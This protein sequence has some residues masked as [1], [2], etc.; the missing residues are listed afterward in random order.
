M[1]ECFSN[2]GTDQLDRLLK[3]ISKLGTHNERRGDKVQQNR[4][5]D[6]HRS[7]YGGNARDSS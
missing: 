6:A 1:L 5:G 3:R 4:Q 7:Y 2:K